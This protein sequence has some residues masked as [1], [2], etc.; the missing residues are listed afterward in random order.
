LGQP[1]CAGA[2]LKLFLSRSPSSGI[3]GKGVVFLCPP[4]TPLPVGRVD[5]EVL[6]SVHSNSENTLASEIQLNLVDIAPAPAFAG[7]EGAHDGMLCSVEMFGRVFV[8]RRVAAADVATLK[9]QPQMNPSVAH[10]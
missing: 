4:G 2:A 6:A 5:F 7:F 10:F 9:A 3:F 8:F 1:S